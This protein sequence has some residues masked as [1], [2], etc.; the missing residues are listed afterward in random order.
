MH[1]LILRDLPV[2][3]NLDRKALGAV[4]GGMHRR[5]SG[6]DFS[7]SSGYAPVSTVSKK[8]TADQFIGQSQFVDVKNGVNAAFVDHVNAN[9]NPHQ[10]ANNTI[11]HF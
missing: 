3:E 8:L 2:T 1:T 6:Y 9:V 10:S 11:N 7:W 4:C 5:P